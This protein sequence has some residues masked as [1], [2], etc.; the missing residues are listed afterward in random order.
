MTERMIFFRVSEVG[1]CLRYLYFLYVLGRLEDVSKKP[2]VIEGKTIHQNFQNEW[3]TTVDEEAKPEEK[4]MF[5]HENFAVLGKADLVSGE[6]VIEIKTTT[7]IP[8]RPYL[9]H[10]RQLNFYLGLFGKKEGTLIY[11][12]RNG[13]GRKEFS[14][15]FDADMFLVDLARFEK[16]YRALT[17]LRVPEREPTP[18]CNFCEY[19]F[20]CEKIEQRNSR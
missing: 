2:E 19:S 11:I 3:I 7:R 14:I 20:L 5:L 9:T 6:K 4:A 12:E 16:L 1:R 8:N 17:E 15:K 18:L 13:N 10:V